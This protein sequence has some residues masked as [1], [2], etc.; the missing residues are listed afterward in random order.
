MN[1]QESSR[2]ILTFE[3]WFL[4]ALSALSFFWLQLLPVIAL[5]ALLFWML[6]LVANGYLTLRTPADWGIILLCLAMLVSVYTSPILDKTITQV[7]RVISGIALFYAIVNWGVTRS[8]IR[9]MFTGFIAAGLGLALIA[10][11]SVSWVFDKVTFIPESLYKNFTL[12]VSDSANPSVMAGSLV[13][14]LPFPLSMLVFRWRKISNYERILSAAAFTLMMV[15]IILTRARGTWV[16][17]AAGLFTIMILFDRRFWI[18]FIL[19]SI[20]TLA[21]VTFS[22]GDQIVEVLLYSNTTGGLEDRLEIW[23]RALALVHDFPYT[24]VG[25]GNFLE[26]AQGFYA[27]DQYASGYIPHA[28]NLFMQVAVDLGIPGLVAWLS[29]MLGMLYLSWRTFRNGKHKGGSLYMGAG[30]ALLASQVVL[31]TNGLTDSVV[32]GMVRPAPLVWIIW[33][34]GAAFGSYS[35]YQKMK[36]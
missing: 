17:A 25:M 2:K 23:S 18:I 16:A 36:H 28:H 14:L 32:W 1:I 20:A 13:L 29:V 33:G 10:P 7:W 34:F 30:A 27:Y 22:G 26:A 19:G 24:G 4:L 15:I 9:L 5:A 8:R 21:L 6:R 11:V 35:T 31:I 3:I 12:L